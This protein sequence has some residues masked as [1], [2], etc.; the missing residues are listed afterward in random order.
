PHYSYA[1]LIGQA[2]MSSPTKRLS[3]NQIYTWISMAYPYFKRG[4]AGW[5]NSIRHNLSLNGC[6]VKI[7]RD[8]GEKG[9]GSWWSI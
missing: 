8:D 1:A 9:K 4:E 7:K 3:L 6:F 2:L 5:Q